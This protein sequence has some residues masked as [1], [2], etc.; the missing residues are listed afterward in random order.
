MYANLYNALIL[1]YLGLQVEFKVY[2]LSGY[3]PQY[4]G[5]FLNK[6]C[7]LLKHDGAK[8]KVY[9]IFLLHLMC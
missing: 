1:N 2:I 7:K 9:L 8:V 3:T 5:Y 6:H 4:N